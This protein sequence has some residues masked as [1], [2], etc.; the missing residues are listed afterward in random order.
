[1]RGSHH[2][3]PRIKGV[4]RRRLSPYVLDEI[5]ERINTISQRYNVKPSWVVATILADALGVKKQ[6]PYTSAGRRNLKV[7]RGGKRAAR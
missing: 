1:M 5:D 6:I 4:I 2:I 7:I 3:Q